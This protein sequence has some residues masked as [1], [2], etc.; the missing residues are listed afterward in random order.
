M[1]RR[2][3]SSLEEAHMILRQFLHTDPV[4][5]RLS[6]KP[7]STIGFEKRH[8]AAFRIEDEAEFVRFMSAEIPPSPPHRR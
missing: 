7:W 1:Q 8:N 5:I 4:G 3:L 2:K 6:G